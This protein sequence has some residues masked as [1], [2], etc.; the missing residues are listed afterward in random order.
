MS[1]GG[2][3]GGLAAAPIDN[4]A[5]DGEDPAALLQDAEPDDGLP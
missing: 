1:V 2:G 5:A 4:E 3:G